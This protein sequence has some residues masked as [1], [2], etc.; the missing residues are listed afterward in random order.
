[1]AHSADLQGLDRVFQKYPDIQAVY[2][3]GSQAEGRALKESDLDL[4]IVPRHP[5][6]RNRRLD[7][8]ADLARHGFCQVDL[9][10]L[11]TEDIVLK[12]EAVRRNRLIYQ[13]EDFDRGEMYSRIVRQYL[14]FLPYLRVQREAFKRRVFL[15]LVRAEVLRKRLNRLSE[16]L[17]ILRRLQR[18]EAE[19]F[20][21]EPERYGSAERFL[22]LA[23]EA[24]TDMGNHLI[25][26]LDLGE[27]NWYSD[28]PR[29]LA[30][31]GYI[32]KDLE[33]KWLR[34]LGFRNVLV[35]EYLDV[36]RRIV[37]EVLQHGL[38]DLE[39]LKRFFAQ[40]L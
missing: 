15:G 26:D 14:D 30:E 27:V 35:H 5:A 32:G 7:I 17:N 11:D 39:A 18:Y 21:G 3:F 23:I 4:A 38:E 8:L 20:L 2:L 6:L 19:E 13:T 10:F 16:C 33:E 1:M 24:V 25:A 36:D 34:M 29:I 31:K 12:Y 40:F 28:I 22:Q 37:Y 9:V